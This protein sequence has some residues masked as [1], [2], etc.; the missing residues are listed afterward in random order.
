M[1]QLYRAERVSVI[2]GGAFGAETA[3]CVRICF[4]AE[5]AQLRE[6]CVRIRRFVRSLKNRGGVEWLT[7]AWWCARRAAP[8]RWS[9]TEL[10]TAAPGPG[11]ARIAQRAVGVNFIDTYFRSG[12]YPW[13]STRSFPERKP[14]AS[15]R[16]WA[17]A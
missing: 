11:E 17:T 14:P 1:T 16:T 9:G 10:E 15:S 5:E 8:R 12:L 7:W 6:A 13:P 3:G 2:D 4:A